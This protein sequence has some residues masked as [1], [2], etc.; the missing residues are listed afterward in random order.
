MGV[1]EG[2]RL[3]SS[4]DWESVKRQGDSAIRRWIDSELSGKSCVVVLI[5][6]G[7]AGRKWVD[8][9]IEKG[10]KDGKGLLGV[11]IHN[12]KNLAGSQDI[13][14]QNPFL[15]FKMGNSPLSSIVKAYDPPYSSSLLVYGYIKANLEGWVEEAIKIRSGV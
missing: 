5:G 8:Y 3:L 14:G 2:Q 11:Y 15:G 13:K 6:A 9:E 4:N 1:I 10:W 7:T 12:L